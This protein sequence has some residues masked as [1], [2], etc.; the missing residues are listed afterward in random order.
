MAVK[1]R[2]NTLG[3]Y[4]FEMLVQTLLKAIIGPGVT[5]FG[6][7]KDGGRD[8][9]FEGEAPFPSKETRWK[10]KWI[11][12]VKYSG[13][14]TGNERDEGKWTPGTFK[15]EIET[16]RKLRREWPDNYVFIVNVRLTATIRSKLRDLISNAGFKGNFHC[17]DGHEVCEFLDIYPKIRR[18]FPQLIG[19]ADIERILNR[20]LYTRSEAFV[21]QWK[22]RLSKFVSVNQ[23]FKA[24]E[25]IRRHHFVVLDGPPEAGKSFIGAAITLAYASE[26]FEIFSIQSP[27]EI[28]QVYN[29]RQKQLYFAD[30]A[31]GTIQFDPTLGNYWS[32]EL[33][34]ILYKLDRKHKLIWTA[35]S[36]ILQEAVAET[37]LR[38]HID[39]F[40]GVYDVLIEIG[41]FT[42]LE[43]A[44]ILYNHVKNS[45]VSEEAREL[46]KERAQ[47]ICTHPNYTPER[48]RQLVEFVL[49][50]IEEELTSTEKQRWLEE[51]D[52]FLKNPSERFQKAYEKLGSSEKTMLLTILDLGT[53]VEEN[54][55]KKE[56]EKRVSTISE[57]P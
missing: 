1:Y 33:P 36:Y 42:L 14:E 2:L 48:I 53:R 21:S 45:K 41:D 20:D 8:A 57:M 34:N 5:S 26:G 17:I 30:D 49:S 11:F 10:G 46:I 32:R 56:Y 51:I 43:K 24:L 40:P 52:R 38:E 3:W 28:F 18:A 37:K 25:L 22:V 54:K 23:Y 27:H 35:R 19:L 6:G 16:I 9:T 29:A 12:Q 13:E 15:R 47:F 31:V 7:T 55:L 44:L 39:D 4:N 50:Q